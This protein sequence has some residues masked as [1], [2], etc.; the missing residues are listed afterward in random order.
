MGLNNKT[1]K[2]YQKIRVFI[3][4]P[5]DVEEE[6][7]RLIKVIKGLN[8]RGNI[9]DSLGVILEPISWSYYLSSSTDTSKDDGLM[10]VKRDESDLFIGIIWMKFGS[11]SALTKAEP[12][13]HFISGREEEFQLAYNLWKNDNKPKIIFYRSMQS[14][15]PAEINTSQF[16]RV[17]DFFSKFDNNI[18][19]HKEFKDT[20]DFEKHVEKDISNHLRSLKEEIKTKLAETAQKIVLQ[21]T[22]T[23]RQ[24]QS[25]DMVDGNLYSVAF[26]SLDIVKHSD[27]VRKHRKSPEKIQKFMN[28]FRELVEQTM[29]E[30]GGEIFNWAGDG[31]IIIFVGTDYHERTLLAGVKLLHDL[32]SFNLNKKTNIIGVPICLRLAASNTEIKYQLPS[33]SISSEMLNFTVHLQEKTARA[34]EYCITKSLLNSVSPELASLFKEKVHLEQETI[35]S[36]Q[37]PATEEVISLSEMIIVSKTFAEISKGIIKSIATIGQNNNFPEELS[38]S[39]DKYYSIIEKFCGSIDTLDERWA[40]K[41]I[42]IFGRSEGSLKNLKMIMENRGAKGEVR[43]IAR[44]KH[45]RFKSQKSLKK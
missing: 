11:Q 33:S 4:F 18:E 44:Q 9:A 2:L 31:G 7:K 6:Q 36:Y 40:E 12:E 10:E 13:D 24:K 8:S 34:N 32:I 25:F 35:H 41:N 37:M 1:H 19:L 22:T 23:S 42:E 43:K 3:A 45:N 26:L 20:K 21:P 17:T 39:L 27:I 29:H 16:Q 38:A 5:P 28:S 14:V 30:Y 15:K